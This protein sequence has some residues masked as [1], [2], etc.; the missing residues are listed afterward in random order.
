MGFAYRIREK[1]P[2]ELLEHVRVPILTTTMGIEER[3]K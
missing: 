2:E 1:G 3:Y